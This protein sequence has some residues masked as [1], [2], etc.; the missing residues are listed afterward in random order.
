MGFSDVRDDDVL[1]AAEVAERAGR[2]SWAA[3]A[4]WL[5]RASH[6]QPARIP[7][8]RLFRGHEVRR[9][10]QSLSAP[11]SFAR[12]GDP[13][14]LKEDAAL[15]SPPVGTADIVPVDELERRRALAAAR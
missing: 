7:G 13:A 12:C 5:R 4:A 10:F 9:W 3:L 8:S 1:T 15:P 2:P 6:P 11:L 14:G